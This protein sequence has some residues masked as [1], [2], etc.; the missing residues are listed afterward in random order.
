MQATSSYQDNGSKLSKF[1]IVAALH[2]GLVAALLHMRVSIDKPHPD[3]TDVFITDTPVIQPEPT[4]VVEAPPTTVPPIFVP[5]TEVATTTPPPVD[6]ITT[7]TVPPP[8][9]PV[10]I[11]EGPAIIGPKVEIDTKPVQKKIFEAATAGNCAV[12]TYPAASARN[13]DMGTVGLALLIAPDGRVTDSRITSSSGFRELDRA[14]VAALSSCRFKPA[15]TNGVPESAWGKIAYV[16]TL[17]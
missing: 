13:G 3:T 8:V 5:R 17:E 11:K 16:W 4:P 2:I 15:T 7:T 6:K 10:V 12:P 9:E 14:A 1:A